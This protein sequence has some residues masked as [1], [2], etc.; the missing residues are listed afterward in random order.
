MNDWIKLNMRDTCDEKY[1]REGDG[2][3]RKNEMGEGT[4]ELLYQT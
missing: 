1:I 2:Y 4:K 3:D